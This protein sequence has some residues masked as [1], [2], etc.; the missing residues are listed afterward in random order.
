MST[1]TN[2]TLRDVM[3]PLDQFAVV[4]PRT[5]FK[6]ALEDMHRFRLGVVCVAQDGKLQGV[7]TDGD[8]RRQLLTHQKP[9]SAL[10]ADDVSVHMT[11]D[12][13][14][15]T[16]DRSLS[17]AVAVMEDARVWDLP[18]VDE[19]GQLLGLLHLHPVVKAL[20]GDQA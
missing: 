11:S 7:V 13:L 1:K 10:F 14:S 15:I 19:D 9:F 18:V 12:P 17:E 6:V 8:I 16:P 3:L 20:M 4:P 2:P 5:L